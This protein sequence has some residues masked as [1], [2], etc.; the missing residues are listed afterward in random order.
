MMDIGKRLKRIAT[1]FDV[2]VLVCN[3]DCH[4][5]AWRSVYPHTHTCTWHLQ[6]T[7]GVV[8][9]RAAA[10]LADAEP[11]KAALGISWSYVPDAQLVLSQKHQP[12]RAASSIDDEAVTE[13]IAE[14]RLS[15]R[16][17]S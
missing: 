2:A 7:N 13:R 10:T 5:C 9:D 15:R 16:A 3:T 1:D 6:M 8:P 14:L 17:V 11:V 4:H 12:R